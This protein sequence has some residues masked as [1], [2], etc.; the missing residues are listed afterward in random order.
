MIRTLFIIFILFISACASVHSQKKKGEPIKDYNEDLFSFRPRYEKVV[1]KKDPLENKTPKQVIPKNDVSVF[2]KEKLDSLYS[3]NQKIIS[4]DGYRI[5]IYTGTSS[6]E[7]RNQRNNI[8]AVLPL[9][10]SY[11]E[12]KSPHFK[13]KVGDFI[14][15]LEAYY[16]YA[17]IVKVFPNAIVV[18]DKVNIVREFN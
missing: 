9:D 11:T 7:A 1:E 16:A 4:A 12:W 5:L 3:Y 18:P 2:L 13:V 10:K 14:D 8:Y 6:E 15:K 17:K